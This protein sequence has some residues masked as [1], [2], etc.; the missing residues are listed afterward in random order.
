MNSLISAFKTVALALSISGLLVA[1]G[2]V[3]EPG[4]ELEPPGEELYTVYDGS[5]TVVI[6]SRVESCSYNGLFDSIIVR[7]CFPALTEGSRWR[8]YGDVGEHELEWGVSQELTLDYWTTDQDIADA[9]TVIAVVTRYRRL[10]EDPAGTLY[11]YEN[12][13]LKRTF[14][15]G[16]LFLGQSW[17]CGLTDGCDWI[18][19]TGSAFDFTFERGADGTMRLTEAAISLP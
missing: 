11:H 4:F 9:P 17:V 2:G 16:R 7:G 5:E 8:T 15:S 1:C 12:M 3:A 14:G 19:L 10:G 6:G 13:S 18:F